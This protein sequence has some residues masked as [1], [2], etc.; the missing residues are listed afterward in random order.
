MENPKRTLEEFAEE[1]VGKAFFPDDMPCEVDIEWTLNMNPNAWRHL[2]TV[3]LEQGLA[4]LEVLYFLI[5]YTRSVMSMPCS[6]DTYIPA[7]L[8]CANFNQQGVVS[9]IPTRKKR[10]TT[11]GLELPMDLLKA[12]SGVVGWKAFQDALLEEWRNLNYVDVDNVKVNVTPINDKIFLNVT[13]DG[14]ILLRPHEDSQ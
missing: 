2:R 1:E 14:Y 9:E 3:L 6:M 10:H 12:T 13:I 11:F 7:M 5:R 4:Q 8:E